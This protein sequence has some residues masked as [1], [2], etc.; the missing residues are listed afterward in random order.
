MRPLPGSPAKH[1][2]R[3]A[4]DTLTASLMP[5]KKKAGAS[6]KPSWTPVSIPVPAAR[7]ALLLSAC[8]A[9]LR[10]PRSARK[11]C[12]AGRCWMRTWSCT[13]AA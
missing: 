6:G 5:A 8:V 10:R 12:G 3:R 13:Y 9:Y 2:F 7:R 1:R 11:R 4:V